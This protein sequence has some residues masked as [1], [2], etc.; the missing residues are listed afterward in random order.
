MCRR[1]GIARL[2]AG[3][4]G[5]TIHFRDDKFADPGGLVKYIT[6]QNGL[7]K[8]KDNKLIVRRDWREAEDRLKGAFAVARDLARIAKQAGTAAPGA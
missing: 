5:A 1:A 4:K 6:D 3:P 7:A 8:V 2:D